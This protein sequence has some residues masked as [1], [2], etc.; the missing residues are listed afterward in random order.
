MVISTQLSLV[1]QFITSDSASL[2]DN[3][4]FVFSL[5]AIFK[6]NFSLFSAI[7]T[8]STVI[9]MSINIC[10]LVHYI[11]RRRGVVGRKRAH[12]ASFLGVVSG[13]FGVGCAA[14]GSVILSS[15]LAAVGAG[16]LLSLLPLHGAEFGV[17]SVLLLLFSIYEIAK[18]VNDPLT[19]SV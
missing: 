19:C 5:I 8:V 16:G 12:T 1:W 7:L 6:T 18:H 2:V 9:L 15:I 17:I 11:R 14:C 4:T 10:L 13:F 3:L